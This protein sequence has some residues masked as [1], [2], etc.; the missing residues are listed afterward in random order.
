[1]QKDVPIFRKL[2]FFLAVRFWEHEISM[3]SLWFSMDC[4]ILH[5]TLSIFISCPKLERQGIMKL[6]VAVCAC[7][8]FRLWLGNF[9]K[10]HNELVQYSAT[11]HVLLLK[12]APVPNFLLDFC[13]DPWGFP[14]LAEF[15]DSP[16]NCPLCL[17]GCMILAM[18]F[19][20]TGDMF[21]NLVSSLNAWFESLSTFISLWVW[22]SL[23][24]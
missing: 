11:V 8:Y 23:K 20:K 3:V 6:S 22:N 15:L 10:K 9:R 1:M 18:I 17:L 24:F 19:A 4:G 2:I 13:C 12:L 21:C 16:C 7:S 14:E 5:C